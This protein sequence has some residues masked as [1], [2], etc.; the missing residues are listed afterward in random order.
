MTCLLIRV[1]IIL[2]M[3]VLTIS[4]ETRVGMHSYSK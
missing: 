4:R 1:I 2:Y 3:P